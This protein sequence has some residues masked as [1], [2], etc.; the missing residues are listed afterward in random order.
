MITSLAWKNIW[1][2]K[3]RSGVIMG[4]IA[5]GVFGGTFLTAFMSGWVLGAVDDCINNQLS[6]IQVHRQGFI[7]NNDVNAVF[8]RDSMKAMIAAEPAVTSVSY[9][10][11]VNGMLASAANIAS[12]TAKGVSVEEEK[13]VSSLWRQ[14]PD[15][16][17][18]FLPDDARMPIVIS[19]E[20][21]EKLKIRLR[22]KIV[23]TFQD[24]GREMQSLAFRVCGIYKT[25]NSAFDETT[26]FV[27]RDDVLPYLALPGNAAHE[28]A[29][30]VGD[31]EDCPPAAARLKAS[32]PEFAVQPWDELNPT[33]ALSYSMTGMMAAIFLGIFLLALSF[34]II[35]TMLMAVL[36]RTRELGML[37]AIG[38]SRRR[39]FRMIMLETV[40]LTLAGGIAGVVLGAVAITFTAQ[41]GVDLSFMVGDSFEDFGYGSTVYPV[42]NAAMFAEV[43][44]LVIAAGILSAIYPARK[45][46]KLNPLDAIRE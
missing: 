37:G 14:I 25:G 15:T 1:R 2:N 21:A 35:N 24:A 33:M 4:A 11:S 44:A 26:V 7:A 31:M 12:I 10:L 38:M 3:L 27:R 36:E 41:S 13:A 32:L 19:R 16:L 17:G 28:A 43:I 23:F 22:S 45:A 5:I 6:H 39:I 42:M 8:D 30:R 34:G 20:T 9:R 46:L 18:S 29:V 40:F